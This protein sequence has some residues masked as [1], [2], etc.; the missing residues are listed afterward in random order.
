MHIIDT[1]SGNNRVI[2]KKIKDS[3]LGVGQIIPP[4]RP[5]VRRMKIFYKLKRVINAGIYL[6]IYHM[7]NMDICGDNLMSLPC[8]V[9]GGDL[10]SEPCE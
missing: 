7:A 2:T 3:G 6:F 9:Y 1:S 8:G 5:D 10:I 4:L